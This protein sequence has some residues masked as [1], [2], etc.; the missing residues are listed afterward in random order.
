MIVTV[1]R[2]SEIMSSDRVT[3]LHI[4]V[5]DAREEM[6]D[7]TPVKRRLAGVGIIARLDG[8]FTGIGVVEWDRLG[9]NIVEVP[10]AVTRCDGWQW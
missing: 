7:Q 1:S 8:K 10:R 5:A 6:S 9:V 2:N 4:S 3:Q